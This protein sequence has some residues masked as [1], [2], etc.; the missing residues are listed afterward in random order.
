MKNMKN[1]SLF[2]FSIFVAFTFA[3]CD[4]I[5][6]PYTEEVNVTEGGRKILLEDFTGHECGNCPY[7]G[8]EAIKLD[9]IYKGRVI[10]VDTHCSFFADTNKNGKFSY[11]FKTAVG[12]ELD[13]FFNIETAG[14]PKGMVNRQAKDGDYSIFSN[15][16][17]NYTAWSS[18][19]AMELNKTAA[20][21]L[22]LSK[23]Y[24][25][26]SRNLN[27]EVEI[28]YL[29]KG[30]INQQLVVYLVEDSIINWQK[31]YGHIPEDVPDFAHRHV[32][33]K[34]LNG[35]WGDRLSGSVKSAGQ[36]ISKTFSTTISS[37]YKHKKCYIVAFVQ[38]NLTK[39]ILQ[40]EEIKLIE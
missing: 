5:T 16:L 17:L 25:T 36:I 30:N 19:I 27:L 20:V 8:L 26:L 15:R 23:N 21:N 7:G 4:E 11:N 34:S 35:T 9:S 31:W 32:L 37:K 10:V 1:S 22:S 2:I 3:A 18:S 33:R 28:E 6:G 40:V 29:E 14:L 39:E 38:N 24:D 13:Q 12:D